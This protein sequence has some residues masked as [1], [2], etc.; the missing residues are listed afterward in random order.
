MLSITFSISKIDKQHKK[1][2]SKGEWNTMPFNKRVES[3]LCVKFPPFVRA[4]N[5]H[6]RNHRHLNYNTTY[7]FATLLF[8]AHNLE[9]KILLN[10]HLFISAGESLCVIF[11]LYLFISQ[12]AL[13]RSE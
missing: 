9:I 6:H 11:L 4:K 2:T 3:T 13:V 5:H 10:L 12:Q 8:H 7:T 1:S